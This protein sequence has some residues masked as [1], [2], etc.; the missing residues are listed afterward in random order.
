M[1]ML[2]LLGLRALAL[3][4]IVASA[5]C[6]ASAPTA[7][8]QACGGA[9]A[10]CTHWAAD[11]ARIAA[12]ACNILPV[13]DALRA[14]TMPAA[15]ADRASVVLTEL[16]FATALDLELLGGGGG[17]GGAE[18]GRAGPGRQGK[19]AAAC[20][21]PGAP[22]PAVITNAAVG[23]GNCSRWSCAVH[24]LWHWLWFTN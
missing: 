4:T 9:S 7:Q 14:V 11:V 23:I 15:A 3:A 13:E 20:R 2:Q 21:G 1:P 6:A 24:Q 5:S 19:G 17:A 10:T 18:G 12:N 16:G 22:S 8:P